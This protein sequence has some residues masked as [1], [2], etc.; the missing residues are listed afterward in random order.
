MRSA[1]AAFALTVAAASFSAPA[2]Q[3]NS[4]LYLP[5]APSGYPSQLQ[6]LHRQ[7][8]CYWFWDCRYINYNWSFC[9]FDWWS[10]VSLSKMEI[11]YCG[12]D[13]YSCVELVT[14][15]MFTY[16]PYYCSFHE[17]SMGAGAI[18][19]VGSGPSAYDILTFAVNAP[20]DGLGTSFFEI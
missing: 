6:S 1:L 16:D 13:P 10:R 2:A 5:S 12:Y 20:N 14:I 19:T 9:D 15:K 8:E 11:D 18:K 17:F 3:A 4:R 7:S